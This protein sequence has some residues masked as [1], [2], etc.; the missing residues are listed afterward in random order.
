MK[1][2]LLILFSTTFFLTGCAQTKT[3]IQN[4]Y[5]Y[6]RIFIPGNLPVDDNGNP[7]RGADTMRV[8]YIETKGATKIQPDQLISPAINTGKDA[9]KTSALMFLQME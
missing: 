3:S 1:N 9:V 6:F 2:L 7:L 5:A 4:S 8:I